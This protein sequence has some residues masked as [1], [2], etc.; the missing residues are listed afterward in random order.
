VLHLALARSGGDLAGFTGRVLAMA[1]VDHQPQQRNAVKSRNGAK[2]ESG[3]VSILR[4][5]AIH[6]SSVNNQSLPAD[7]TY[8]RCGSLAANTLLGRF[9]Y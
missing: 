9:D 1:Q 5:S 8:R 4:L 3:Q 6:P 7:H 2:G